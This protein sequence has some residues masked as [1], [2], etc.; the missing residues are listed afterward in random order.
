MRDIEVEFLD[1][2]KKLDNLIKDKFSSEQGVTEY[3]NRMKANDYF[4]SNLFSEWSRTYRH[5]IHIRTVRNDI[6]HNDHF[7]CEAEDL[8]YVLDFYDEIMSLNDPLTLYYIKQNI[9]SERAKKRAAKAQSIQ[10]AE[11]SNKKE[12]S[13]SKGPSVFQWLLLLV[14]LAIATMIIVKLYSR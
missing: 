11:V 9:D 6:M 12:E 8:E 14:L 7:D 13:E 5:L 1:E 10:D 2:Y 3:I 4:G